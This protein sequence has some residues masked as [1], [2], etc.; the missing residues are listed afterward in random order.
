M[1]KIIPFFCLLLTACATLINGSRQDIPVTTNPPGATVTEEETSQIT[2]STLTL[3]RKRDYLL[4]ITKEGYKTEQIKLER[5]VNG[6]A[7]CN[8]IGLSILGTAIDTA[9]GAIW[10]L[11]PE[12]I[13][14]T[15][16]PLSEEE[17]A[18]EEKRLNTSTLQAH[19]ESLEELKDAKLLTE[20]QYAIFRDLA[21]HTEKT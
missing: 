4:T 18:E 7:A 20:S 1:S 14:V 10:T 15:L 13:V 8:I 5:V 6:T 2:P 16:K 3:D 21:I 17:K 12:N 11:V 9:S 19:L